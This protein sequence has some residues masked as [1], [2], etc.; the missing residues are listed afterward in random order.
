MN[1]FVWHL[2][3]LLAGLIDPREREAVLGDIA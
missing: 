1:G 2:V 3:E